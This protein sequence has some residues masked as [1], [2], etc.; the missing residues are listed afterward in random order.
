M[1]CDNILDSINEIIK[2]KEVYLVGGYLR[3]YFLNNEISSDRDLVI[4]GDSKLLAQEI[5][6]KLNGTFVELDNENEIY[7]VV[8]ED[9]INYFDIS[10]ALN[11][12]ILDDAKRRDF[13]I[14]SIFYDLNKKGVIAK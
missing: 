12:N 4:L 13:T 8:L 1:F 9:K 11:N 3:N 14:N 6:Q 5:A 10:Q 2:N 7:R